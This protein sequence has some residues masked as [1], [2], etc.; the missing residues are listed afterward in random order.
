MDFMDGIFFAS[1]GGVYSRIEPDEM[2]R[3]KAA[4]E[5]LQ[6]ASQKNKQS[7]SVKYF[8]D[9]GY[10]STGYIIEK[11]TAKTMIIRRYS[12]GRTSEN[13]PSDY[14][15]SWF[16]PHKRVMTID[17]KNILTGHTA[18]TIVAYEQALERYENN[19]I[20]INRA[21]RERFIHDLT[22]EIYKVT[23]EQVPDGYGIWLHS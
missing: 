13:L 16:E 17:E 7:D 1:F 3:L 5:D 8:R 22:R 9:S 2:E 21:I 4:F 15:K 11:R 18:L 14:N 20:S 23:K 19:R 6:I 12:N 10:N